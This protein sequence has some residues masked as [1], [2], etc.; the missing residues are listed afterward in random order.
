MA[1]SKINIAVAGLGFGAE[2]IPIYQRHPSTRMYAVCQRNEAKLNAIGDAFDIE[3]RYSSYEELLKDPNVDAVHINTPIPEHGRQS[4]K[5]LKAG[6]HVACTVP[7]ATSIDDCRR[8]V[9]L[10]KATGLKYMMMETVV[11]SREYLFMKELLDAGKLGKLQFVQASHQQDMDGWPDYWPGLPPMWYA[12]HCVGPVAG[13]IGKSAEYASCFGSGTIRKE[14]IAKYGSPF[15]IETAHIK[16]KDTDVSARI[17]RSLFDIA[18]QYRESIDVYGSKTSVEWPL[19]EHEP[20]IIHTAKRP[21]PKIPRAV[22]VPDYAKR[23]PK[24][25]RPFTTKGVYD[26]GKKMHLSFTQGAG[27]GGSH[28]HLANE[29]V[30]SIVEDRE[31]FPNAK[32]SANWSCVGLCSHQSALKGGAIVKLPSFTI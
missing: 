13:L 10:V 26:L 17:I 2:F 20:L 18:R 1:H 4:I 3:K 9:E 12:T 5:A 11:Y 32:Q 29:F 15:A 23:L 8:I 22:R 19:V 14:M 6:K 24:E 16:F 30:M 25:I 21:E 27:H 7:M 28:P 31:P